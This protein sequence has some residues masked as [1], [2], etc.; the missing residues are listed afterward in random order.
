MASFTFHSQDTL[1]IAARI[2]AGLSAYQSITLPTCMPGRRQPLA[3]GFG[4]MAV[5]PV[6]ALICLSSR[7][8][9]SPLTA[10]GWAA[11][12]S[13]ACKPGRSLA[14][15]LPTT[16]HL[17]IGLIWTARIPIWAVAVRR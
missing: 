9:R 14:A 13:S 7:E 4:D 5:L 2:M 12:Q 11:K 17:L 6:M 10:L 1:A 3:A 15:T 16:G 8:T